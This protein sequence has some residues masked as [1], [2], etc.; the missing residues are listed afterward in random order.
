MSRNVL[1]VIALAL[2]GE[3]AGCA[4]ILPAAQTVTDTAAALCQNT[5]LRS[6]YVEDR[7]LL[8][9]ISG[10]AVAPWVEAACQALPVAQAVVDAL[11]D[12]RSNQ[13]AA[14]AALHAAEQEG[15]L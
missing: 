8:E 1:I 10:P 4:A 3:T 13:A 14:R 15:L 11:Q 12:G 7:L 2:G 6:Q 5:L 9:G